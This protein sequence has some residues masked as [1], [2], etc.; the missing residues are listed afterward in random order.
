MYKTCNKLT[1]NNLSCHIK[2]FRST[3]KQYTSLVDSNKKKIISY[4]SRR[5]TYDQAGVS[6]RHRNATH[7][8]IG[9]IQAFLLFSY[10]EPEENGATGIDGPHMLQ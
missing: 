4:K 2:L 3:S 10:F 8:L 5:Q 1:I 7:E 9:R 6:Y